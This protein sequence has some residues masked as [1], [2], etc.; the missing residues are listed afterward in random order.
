MFREY[1]PKWREY[2]DESSARAADKVHD[3]DTAEL[4]D[5]AVRLLPREEQQVYLYAYFAEFGTKAEAMDKLKVQERLFDKKLSNAIGAYEVL[6]CLRE[7]LKET[8]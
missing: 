3:P 2:D 1:Q 6:F 5:R 8:G 4:T 7:I